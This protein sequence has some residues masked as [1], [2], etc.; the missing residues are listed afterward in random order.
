M[1]VATNINSSITLYISLF[2]TTVY[3]YTV[4]V[5]FNLII[6][7]FFLSPPISSDS[8][9][10][11][12]SLSSLIQFPLIPYSLPPLS[13]LESSKQI[14]INYQILQTH[15]KSRSQTLQTHINYNQNYER[16]RGK[17][18]RKRRRRSRS[19]SNNKKPIHFICSPFHLKTKNP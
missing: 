10:S 17:R 5:A 15:S 8:L 9:S 7:I 16:R 18:R 1:L 14:N 12:F 19:S 2:A 6:L 13:S 4:T 11:P 3:I